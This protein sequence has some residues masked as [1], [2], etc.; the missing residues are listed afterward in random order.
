MKSL[1]DEIREFSHTQL[2]TFMYGLFVQN[3]DDDKVN[4]LAYEACKEIMKRYRDADMG[5]L[6][7]ENDKLREL[8]KL[9]IRSACL[10]CPHNDKKAWFACDGC[11]LYV[12]STEL[13]IE[14]DNG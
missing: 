4:E 12:Y 7:I 13:G 11:N 14:V 5:A 9:A 8:V 1:L 10:A 2:V 6:V 3:C